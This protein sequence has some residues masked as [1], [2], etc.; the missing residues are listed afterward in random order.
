MSQVRIVKST[1]ENCEY[2][3]AQVLTLYFE[4][5][6]TRKQI[7]HTAKQ[8]RMA[9]KVKPNLASRNL[10]IYITPDDGLTKVQLVD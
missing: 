8:L 5:A 7:L 1:T 10:T 2:S 4:G 9:H 6:P 3:A